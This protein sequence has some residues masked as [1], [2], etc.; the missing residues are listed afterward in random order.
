MTRKSACISY[1]LQLH[2]H[3]FKFIHYYKSLH[4]ATSILSC[5]PIAYN[6]TASLDKLTCADYVDFGKCRDRF[7]LFLVLKVIQLLGCKTQ[8]FHE[9]WQQKC[10]IGTKS[11]NGRSRDH[12]VHANVESAG[13]CCRKLL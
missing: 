4:S 2:K 3:S 6:T 13:H 9:R 10:P 11:H 7:G 8:S 5:S 1:E 12:L